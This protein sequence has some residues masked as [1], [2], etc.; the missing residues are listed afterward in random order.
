MSEQLQEQQEQQGQQEQQA[1][2][3]PA[4]EEI[5]PEE[6]EK[7]KQVV[8]EIAEQLGEQS[9]KP[10][11]Q[12]YRIIER[13]GIERTQEFLQK[14]LEVES[15]GGLMVAD[16]SRRRTPGGVFFFL[17]SEG[18]APEERDYIRYAQEKRYKKK[19]S[20][21][22]GKGKQQPAFDPEVL[23]QEFAALKAEVRGIAMTVKLTLIGRPEKVRPV[24][25]QLTA[26]LLD[27]QA[28]KSP[29]LPKGLP[30]VKGST[31][32]LVMVANKQWKKVSD[33]IKNPEDK[34][35]IEGYCSLDKEAPGAITVRASSVT[36]AMLQRAKRE[37]QKAETGS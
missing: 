14:A 30:P 23:K 27:S 11:R 35:I 33:A 18:V 16:G 1:S 17:V 22:K 15:Q 4:A 7:R 26:F 21:S 6:Q 28:D 8:A 3:E 29:T 13:V 24:G 10:R 34:L 31:T 2:Q 25:Q 32:Y 19:K 36:T 12:I 9:D 20:K 5:S 37:K